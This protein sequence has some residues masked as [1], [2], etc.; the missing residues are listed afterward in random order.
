MSDKIAEHIDL[1]GVITQ[2][3]SLLSDE[4]GSDIYHSKSA[5]ESDETPDLSTHESAVETPDLSLIE[6][7]DRT[8]DLSDHESVVETPD[9]CDHEP[10]IP[11][12]C[13]SH[14]PLPKTNRP[15]TK[16][17]EGKHKTN[18]KEEKEKTK[19]ALLQRMKLS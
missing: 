2:I 16:V 3:L 5:H 4:E 6:S 14:G 7:T 15:K 9:L 11:G 13:P 1:D 12:E 10:D 18:I 8:M 17:K 19:K